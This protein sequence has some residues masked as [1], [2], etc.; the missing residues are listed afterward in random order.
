MV[1]QGRDKPRLA[2]RLEKD[3][4]PNNQSL[5]ASQWPHY[6]FVSVKKSEKTYRNN[7]LHRFEQMVQ[8]NNQFYF[9]FHCYSLRCFTQK[10][11]LLHS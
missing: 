7:P 6:L 10:S 11:R 9:A 1:S 5:K 8:T 2:D 4:R 3:K